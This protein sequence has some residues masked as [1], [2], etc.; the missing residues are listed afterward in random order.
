[1]IFIST[2]CTK[3]VIV[4]RI[5]Y[6]LIVKLNLN[7]SMASIEDLSDELLF[8]IWN[9]LNNLDVF[10][11]FMGVNKRFDKLVR[12]MSYTR[13]IQLFDKDSNHNYCSLSDTL[14][15]RVCFYLLPQMHENIECLT[16]GPLSMERILC[17]GQYP[18]LHQLTL[19]NFGHQS[20]RH[21]FTGKKIL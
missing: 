4:F 17:V 12:D 15:D 19:V 5:E 13:S 20:T 10:Y 9:K 6:C 7:F 8:M 21:Y 16:L 1:M 3:V 18:H 14:L 2:L 11:S